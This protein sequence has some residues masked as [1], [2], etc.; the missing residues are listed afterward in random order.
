MYVVGMCISFSNNTTYTHEIG[1]S[2]TITIFFLPIVIVKTNTIYLKTESTISTTVQAA[3]KKDNYT[4]SK[5]Y[6]NY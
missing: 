6:C 4:Y 2:I 3:N 5:K 1:I